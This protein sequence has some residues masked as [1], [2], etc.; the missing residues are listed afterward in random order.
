M[1]PTG[2]RYDLVN[3][4]LPDI[5]IT[6]TS[7]GLK[8]YDSHPFALEHWVDWSIP[9]LEHQQRA[10]ASERVVFFTPPTMARVFKESHYVHELRNH[11]FDHLNRVFVSDGSDLEWISDPTVRSSQL[12]TPGS[13]PDFVLIPRRAAANAAEFGNTMVCGEVERSVD[14]EADGRPI[15]LVQ[16]WKN[17]DFRA[18]S[19]IA[20]LFGQMCSLGAAAGFI[21][22]YQHTWIVKRP[23]DA[24]TTLHVRNSCNPAQSMISAPCTEA[25]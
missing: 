10:N 7:V 14:L 5:V 8:H 15:D 24:P 20:Q 6:S 17:G 21:S 13:K 25:G 9:V 18:Q 16:L 19:V 22:S 3:G 2:T 12:S 23:H 11:I 4:K 1:Q